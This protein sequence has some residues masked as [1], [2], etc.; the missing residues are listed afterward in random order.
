VIIK[1]FKEKTVE[2]LYSNIQSNL[3]KYKGGGFPDLYQDNDSCYTHDGL[4]F[5]NEILESICGERVN[6]VVNC[7]KMY[8]AMD[9]LTPYVAK[10]ERLWC[11]L[12]HTVLFQYS[13]ERWPILDNWSDDKAIKHIKTH[14]FAKNVRN[15]E[16]DNVG[17]RLWWSSYVC[18]KVPNIDLQSALE[19]LFYT[20]DARSQIMDKP[21]S[22]LNMNLFSVVLGKMHQSID[23]D[24]ML[25]QRNVNR[26][27]ME[28]VNMLG[29]HKLLS[30]LSCD[31]VS[32]I[33]LEVDNKI[34][35][36]NNN[37]D[38]IVTGDDL[39]S[40]SSDQ[41]NLDLI[42]PKDTLRD[43]LIQFDNEVIRKKFPHTEVWYK[44]LSP[45]MLAALLYSRPVTRED[46][47]DK[48][49]L[50]L[51]GSIHQDELEFLDEIIQIIASNVE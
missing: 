3:E 33:L 22:A 45:A 42:F 28:E 16:R 2:D 49:P 7:L 37:P 12:A 10:D 40:K 4:T 43:L 9:G 27:Y 18:D 30:A 29:G 5:N 34:L 35:G 13:K 6:D 36:F 19:T 47:C 25:L 8:E 41:S 17:S 14:F 32:N 46:F 26:P 38:V 23:S 20:M 44:F 21:T 15:F 11:Y 1:F 51:R 50:H 39:K 48:V 24:Q 31:Q